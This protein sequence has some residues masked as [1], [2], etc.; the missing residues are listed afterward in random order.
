MILQVLNIIRKFVQIL[1]RRTKKSPLVSMSKNLKVI[2]IL[3]INFKASHN[4]EVG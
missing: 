4:V 3:L 1:L 2:L